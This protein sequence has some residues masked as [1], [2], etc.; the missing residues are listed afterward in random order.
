MSK[1]YFSQYADLP[2]RGDTFR[3]I[4]LYKHSGVYFDLDV[5]FLRDITELCGRDFA[6]CWEKQP[7]ANNALLYFKTPSILENMAASITAY[8]TFRP[9]SVFNYNNQRLSELMVYP[10]AFFDPVWQTG[11]LTRY[12]YPVVDFDGFFTAKCN[13]SSYRGFFPGAYAYHWHNRWDLKPAPGSFFDV[14]SREITAQIA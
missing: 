11:N 14:F 2:L 13:V 8:G 1:L 7:Y 5:F 4:V 6:Y 9:W 12:D 10:C 3:S